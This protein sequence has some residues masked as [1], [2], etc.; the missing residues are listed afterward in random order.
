MTA[1][2]RTIVAIGLVTAVLGTA[3]LWAAPVSVGAEQPRPFVRRVHVRVWDAGAVAPSVAVN[4]PVI[5]V[6]ATLKVA[7]MSGLLDRTL[8]RARTEIKAKTGPDGAIRLDMRGRDVVA[9][10]TALVDSGPADIVS[11][12]DGRGGRVQIRID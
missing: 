2:S 3:L 10:W 5:L 11:V 12:D 6:T 4:I 7:S 9:L 8:D 1:R